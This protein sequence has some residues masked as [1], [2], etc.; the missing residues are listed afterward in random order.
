MFL[1]SARMSPPSRM[2]I[3]RPMA[4]SPLT[5][6][7][8]LRRI[9]KAAPDLGDVAQAE[10]A[11]ANSEIDARD[12]LLGAECARDAKRQRFVAGLDGAGRLDDVLRLQRRD[13]APSD[14][15]PRLAS[16]CIENS[17]KIFSSCAP[18]ISIFETSA[19]LQ[20][21]RA[22][23]LDIVAQLAMRE[24]VGGEA[25]D[26][27]ERVAELVVEAR[28]DD[29]GRQRVADV[30]DA[31]ADVVPDVGDSLAVALPFRLTKIVVTPARRVAAQEIELRRFLQLALEPLGDLLERVLDGR[32][33][34]GGL[35]DHG[36][37][38]EGRVFVA[39]E[40][41]IRD[42]ARQPPQRSSDRRR[43]SDCLSA[44]SERLKPLMAP[45]RAAEPSGPDAAPARP[46]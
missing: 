23:V 5:R 14:R 35:H 7:M 9:G 37:D 20:Q 39:A 45:I 28:S 22:H 11:S 10:H 46:R 30:A 15:C 32:A 17:T 2:A 38:D 34:P 19:T 40:P 27:A 16:S 1:P 44:H 18:R 26:D 6:N 8:R 25:V 12:V 36:L 13:Q 42:D 29:A 33:G 4:G 41:E 31:L 24:A 3:A 21:L 43:A